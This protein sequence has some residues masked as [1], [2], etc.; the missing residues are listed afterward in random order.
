[1]LNDKDSDED[2]EFVLFLALRRN[3][4]IWVYDDNTRREEYGEYYRLCRKLESH[5]DTFFTYFRSLY[6]VLHCERT[7]L[8]GSIS[9]EDT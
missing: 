5:E 8:G 3:K 7:A 2:E 4:R 6:V 1:M 9:L